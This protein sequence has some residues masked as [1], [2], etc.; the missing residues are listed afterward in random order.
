MINIAVFFLILAKNLD[1]R[2]NF[3]QGLTKYACKEVLPRAW[4][5]KI[6]M[7]K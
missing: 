3:Y 6:I 7:D 4:E 1:N 2:D 5:N